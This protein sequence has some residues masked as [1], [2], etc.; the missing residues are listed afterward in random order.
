MGDSEPRLT[1]RELEVL[2]EIATGKT[3]A[4]VAKSVNLGFE[5]VR[6]IAAKLRKKL[7]AHSKVELATWAIR[8]IKI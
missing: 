5:T 4:D 8:N 1:A 2:K 7:N 6:A 3:L